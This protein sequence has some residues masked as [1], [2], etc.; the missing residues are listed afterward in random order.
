MK[1]FAQPPF[2]TTY[3]GASI[4][5]DYLPKTPYSGAMKRIRSHQFDGARVLGD[6]GVCRQK[7]DAFRGGLCNQ[8]A[9]KGITVQ[10]R[11]RH[12]RQAMPPIKRKLPVAV[13]QNPCRLGKGQAAVPI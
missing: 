12:Q 13:R 10:H 4:A 2:R 8:H 11:Q 3:F 6:L 5:S 1:P 9:V 7:N